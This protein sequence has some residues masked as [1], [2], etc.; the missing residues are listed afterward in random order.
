MREDL[1]Y[2]LSFLPGFTSDMLSKLSTMELR[3]IYQEYQEAIDAL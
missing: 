1:I 3:R 2:I